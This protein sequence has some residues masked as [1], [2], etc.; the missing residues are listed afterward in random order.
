MN[1]NIRM[2]IV[3]DEEIVHKS[4]KRIF[5]K[6]PYQIDYVYSGEEALSKVD[7]AP[8]DIVITD[9]M[10][11]GLSGM[12][13]L[14][15]LVKER[16]QITVIIF[17]GFATVDSVREA[18]KLGA[19]DYVPKPFTPDELRDVVKNA[20]QARQ[21]KSGGQMLDLMAIV[22]HDLRSPIAVVHTNAETLCKGYFG[23]LEP[24]QQKTIESIIRN[25]V[26]LE[27]IIRSYLDLQNV[28]LQDMESFQQEVRLVDDVLRPVLDQPEL[29]ENFRRMS[30][31]VAFRT[32][33]VVQADPSLLRIVFSNLVSNAIKYGK[34]QTA[35]RVEVDAD[36]VRCVTSVTNQGIGISAEDIRTRL[37]Q[38]GGRLKQKG[39]E[40]V[41]GNGLGLYICR[42]IVDKHQ[43][44]IWCESSP[45]EWTR[46]LVA[47][48]L[49]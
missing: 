25:C 16:P 33:P 18:L 34:E 41:K 26:Y 20:I 3:D 27:D 28:D 45:G 38:K 6:D 13:L 48:P 37:F 30:I 12:D 17:T 31:E 2:L 46:F 47:L 1:T 36:D 8:Y 32:N 19:F 39:T 4:C 15:R 49:S 40:G 23:K 9:L 44:R 14:K 22:S 29:R 10:M 24:Q 5:R 42:T 11:P 7:Q 21:T 35:I 43:G